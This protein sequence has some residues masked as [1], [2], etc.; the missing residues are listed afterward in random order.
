MPLGMLRSHADRDVQRHRQAREDLARPSIARSL[1]RVGAVVRG[2]GACGVGVVCPYMGD[3]TPE[4]RVRIAVMQQR[5]R[6][7]AVKVG[8]LRELHAAEAPCTA[9]LMMTLR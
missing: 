5:V 4:A 8:Y 9:L 7:D 2:D 6:R 3:G 1:T